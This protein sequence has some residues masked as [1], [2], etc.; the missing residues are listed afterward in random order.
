MDNKKLE[1]ILTNTKLPD[2]ISQQHKILLRRE[3]LNSTQFEKNKFW[4]KLK[5]F[6]RIAGVVLAFA[7]L[8]FIILPKE[9][10]KDDFKNLLSLSNQYYAGFF[11]SG[12]QSDFNNQVKIFGKDSS[13]FNLNVR[14]TI[15]FQNG[16]YK[17]TAFDKSGKTKLDEYLVT[18]NNTYRMKTP[19]LYCKTPFSEME[20]MNR[21]TTYT[22]DIDSGNVIDSLFLKVED[23]S[24][25]KIV[26]KKQ[27]NVDEVNDEAFIVYQD[28]SK[29]GEEMPNKSGLFYFPVD[30]STNLFKLFSVNPL[31]IVQNLLKSNTV[32]VKGEEFVSQIKKY[33][34]V[35]ENIN[36][37]D[38][39]EVRSI[40]VDMQNNFPDSIKI[41]RVND[42]VVSINDSLSSQLR[43]LID[44]VA[45]DKK[46]S[47]IERISI[48][49]TNGQI[50][51]VKHS[52]LRNGIKVNLSEIFF[53]DQI[54]SKEIKDKFEITEEYK[55]LM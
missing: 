32:I 19:K 29:N 27:L 17:F 31:Q 4:L 52:V 46:I 51:S 38:E 54:K 34:V 3:L 43:S 24:K 26:V 18:D 50:I 15:D 45:L 21:K 42:L 40:F 11:N 20:S 48:D 49:P 10:N 25:T 2:K 13:E 53:E 16:R 33:C 12:T 30:K 36:P 55:K 5:P 44:S 7:V 22:I 47:K 1:K 35:I 8:L 9:K 14:Q 23:L 39:I 41:K 37:V 28:E 6:D